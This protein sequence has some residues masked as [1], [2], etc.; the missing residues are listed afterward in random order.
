MTRHK[1]FGSDNHAGVHPAVLRAIA[2]AMQ[3]PQQVQLLKAIAED[4]EQLAARLA[5]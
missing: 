2:D 1:S 5:R 4:C 3:D